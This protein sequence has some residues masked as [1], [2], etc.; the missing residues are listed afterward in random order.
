MNVC[1]ETRGQDNVLKCPRLHVVL[2]SVPFRR[3]NSSNAQSSTVIP[4][5]VSTVTH[6]LA[7]FHS[8][9]IAIS[10]LMRQEA[11]ISQMFAIV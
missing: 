7:R 3:H 5:D 9:V 8:A 6:S 1:S 10:S 2:I 11:Q 4:D